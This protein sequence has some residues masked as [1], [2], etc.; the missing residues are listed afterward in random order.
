MSPDHEPVEGARAPR[1]DPLDGM[2]VTVR[3]RFDAPIDD[4]WA[5]LSDVERMGGLGP[6]HTVA[7]WDDPQRGAAVGATFHG[8]N[9]VDDLEW[10]VPCTIVECDPPVRLAWAVVD[11]DEPSSVWTY[12]LVPD[13]DGTVV[14]Q[15]FRHGPGFSYLRA[16]VDRRPEKTDVYVQGRAERLRNNMTATLEA[17][18][19][20]LSRRP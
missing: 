13:G 7:R 8:T 17:A 14:T 12:D 2:T 9:K 1:P 11:V 10:T 18:A 4:V 3:H 15:T 20:V 16:R 6:E 5:L 19:E